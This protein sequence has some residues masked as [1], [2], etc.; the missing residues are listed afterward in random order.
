MRAK[1]FIKEEDAAAAPEHDATSTTHE[2]KSSLHSLAKHGALPAHRFDPY[3]FSK[4]FKQQA[5]RSRSSGSFSSNHDDGDH[6]APQVQTAWH[7]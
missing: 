5:K 3:W 6:G 1:L 2:P 4:P 7:I